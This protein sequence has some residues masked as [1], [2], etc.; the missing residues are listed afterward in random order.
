MLGFSTFAALLPQLRDAWG[1]T[2]AQ[3]GIVGGGFFGGYVA[4]VSFWTSRTDRGDARNVYRVAALVSALASAGFGLLARGLWSGLAFQALLGAGI[5]GTYM[6][7]LRLLSDRVSGARLS[8][9]IAFYTASFGVGTAV[10]LA[11]AGAVAPRFGWRAAFLAAAAGPIAAALL[12][13]ALAPVAATIVEKAPAAFSFLRRRDVAGYVAGYFVHCLELFGSRSWM[14]AFLTFSASLQPR[15]FPWS[16]PAIAAV[17][18]LAS[19]PSS[20]AGNEVALRIGRRRWILLAMTASGASGVVLG[21][22][23]SWHWALV[24]AL[25]AAYSMM[26]MAD[27]AT[28]T[29]GLVAV[30]PAEQRGAAMGFYSLAGFGG[31]V[32][33]PVVFGAALDAAGGASKSLAWAAAYASIGLG[34]LLAPVVARR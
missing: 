14:V 4:T 2:N 6:P 8:R 9:S 10:S 23:A 27:S 24:V 22:A 33:G 28:L 34:C 20:I 7:G 21:F 19:V 26:V 13:S 15:G 3:A 16:A 31:G 30:A 5:A 18:N 12:V 32:I 25:L 11:A 1:L 17:V 29:A